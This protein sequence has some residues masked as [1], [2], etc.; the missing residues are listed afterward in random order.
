M[1]HWYICIRYFLSNLN[2]PVQFIL[3]PRL[4]LAPRPRPPSA[5]APP[6][7]AVIRRDAAAAFLAKL[8]AL[9]LLSLSPWDLLLSLRAA[10]P[11]L[12]YHPYEEAR[13]DCKALPLPS[14]AS[15]SSSRAYYTSSPRPP[16][17]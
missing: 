6:V 7:R 15:P 12:G 16:R 10:H 5:P 14:P 4:H 3:R 17:R 1:Y 8:A 2:S 11:A 13:W 9:W